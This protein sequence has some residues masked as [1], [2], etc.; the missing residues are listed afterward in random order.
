M[1]V[2][3]CVFLSPFLDP[4]VTV[5]DVEALSGRYNEASSHALAPSSC[6]LAPFAGTTEKRDGENKRKIFEC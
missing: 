1:F 5:I 2:D 6:A 3:E 4:A